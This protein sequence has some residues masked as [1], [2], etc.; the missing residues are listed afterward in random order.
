MGDFRTHT[1]ENLA[2]SLSDGLCPIRQPA[3]QNSG[4]VSTCQRHLSLATIH[5][6][7]P[8]WDSGIGAGPILKIELGT[9]PIAMPCVLRDRLRDSA[10]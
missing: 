9:P 1:A 6:P 2:A 8:A 3:V 7:K 4:W 10:A 5:H